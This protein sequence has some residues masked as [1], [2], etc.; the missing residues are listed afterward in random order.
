VKLNG[1]LIAES[2]PKPLKPSTL[3]RK[4][5]KT[6][7][8]TNIGRQ[9]GAACFDHRKASYLDVAKLDLSPLRLCILAPLR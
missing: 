9:G 1:S 3:R 6:Q 8:L 7:G 4:D 5:T 2:R